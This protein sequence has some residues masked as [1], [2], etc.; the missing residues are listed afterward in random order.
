MSSIKQLVQSKALALALLIGVISTPVL[1][2][3][4]GGNVTA[5][6]H[7]D[8]PGLVLAFTPD[9]PAQFVGSKIYEGLLEYSKDLKPQPAL[10]KSWDVS[11]DGLTYTFHL[12]PGVKWNDGQDFT[13][14]DVVFSLTQMLPK[15]S[16]AARIALTAVQS[17]D[18]PDAGTVVIKL[19][20]PMPYF[21]MVFPGVQL[22]MMPRHVYENTDYL[23]N[24]ANAKPVGTG[25]FKLAEWKRGSYIRLV[26][27]D[28]YWKKGLPRLQSVTFR[29]IPDAASRAIALDAGDIQVATSLDLDSTDIKRFRTDQNFS[30]TGAGWEYLGPMAMLEMNWRKPLLSD[31][32]FRKALYLA[33]DRNFILN[34]IW[35]GE[36]R[37][38]SG[39]ISSKMPFY[40]SDVPR[41]DFNPEKAKAQLEEI[42]LHA[43]AS[44]ARHDAKGNRVKVALLVLPG[45][46]R[47]ARLGEYLREAWRAVG[48]DVDLQVTELASWDERVSN[49]NY[50]I[51]ITSLSQYADPAL[52][53]QRYFD[54]ANIRKGTMY[55]D[56]SGY[57]NPDIDNW[58]RQARAENDPQRRADLYMRI[59]RKLVDDVAMIWL[60]ELDKLTVYRKSVHNLI[61][62]AFGQRGSWDQAYI[63]TNQ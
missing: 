27:N 28:L 3:P 52:G 4:Q 59:Q 16:T 26:K 44:G 21:L 38:A 17:V 35:L 63:D 62:T 1:S 34:R 10:A 33:I 22:P 12:Q 5:V 36:G 50:D 23:R 11:G 42:G 58:F 39:P 32:R 15:T 48:V 47:Y 49:W 2:E 46:E 51:A 57:S 9:G 30:V 6:L 56:T 18:A 24:P 53:I 45:D 61:T 19:K 43:D 60:L 20:K 8:P 7:S 14:A 37:V 55:T 29:I 25:P 54:S 40:T 31:V 13:S 41:Y